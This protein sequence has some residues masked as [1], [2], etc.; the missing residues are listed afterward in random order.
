M[1]GPEPKSVPGDVDRA[2]ERHAHDMV[3]M[4]VAI[5]QIRIEA[6]LFGAKR[7]AQGA[8]PRAAIENQ[9]LPATAQLD[10][11]GIAAIAQGRVARAGNGAANAPKAYRQLGRCGLA[12]SGSL[13]FLGT[14][15]T[16]EASVISILRCSTITPA[17]MNFRQNAN[18]A[19]SARKRRRVSP[20]LSLGSATSRTAR[21]DPASRPR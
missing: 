6:G 4:T 18:G 10:A 2:E 9:E 8:Q 14:S 19:Q 16:A 20:R 11:G 21:R 7:L 3:E 15:A 1:T 5:E 17:Q 12:H 13:A